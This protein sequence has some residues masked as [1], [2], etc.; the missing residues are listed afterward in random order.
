MVGA[1]NGIATTATVTI[2]TS[3]AAVLD[4]NGFDQSLAGIVN[5][6]TPANAIITNSS[7][8]ADATLTLTGL[9]SYAGAIKD[10]GVTTKLNLTVNGGTHTL[11]GT[12]TFMGATTVSNGTLLVNGTLSSAAT[13]VAVDG[14][15]LAGAGTISRPVNVNSGATLQPGNPAGTLTIGGDL[16]IA[17]GATNLFALGASSATV[18]V[19]GNLTLDGSLTVTDAGGFGPGTNTL[20]T[21]TGTLTD[22]TLTINPLPGGYTGAINTDTAGQ[23][24]LVVT[25]SGSPPVAGFTAV[26]LSGVEPLQVVFTD[27]S[28]D[29][30]TSWFWDFNNDAAVDSMDQNPTNVFAAGTWTVSL[31][32]S[33]ANGASSA[34]TTNITVI[35]VQES[36]EAFYGVT[37]DGTDSDGDGVSNLDEFR[38]GFNPT[39][40]A[41]YPRVLDL[42]RTGNDLTISYRASNG[43]T[44][45]AGAAASRTNVVDYSTGTANGGYDGSFAGLFTNVLSGGDGSGVVTNAVEIGGGTNAPARYFRTRVL[46]P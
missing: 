11:S 15:T 36:W 39:N 12:S 41:A 30:P 6:G 19:T 21:Y 27:T 28:T 24:D 25:G 32:A 46:A 31:V 1:T 17:S 26:P 9:S 3:G 42:T 18:A 33:N 7:T 4:L 14:G 44:N 16:T 43:D 2:G 10:D 35:T 38:A 23:V 20:F 34:Y 13:A 29:F 37:A 45:Y 40:A 5:G 8:T 22:N